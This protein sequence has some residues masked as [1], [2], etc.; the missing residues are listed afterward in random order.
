MFKNSTRL[1]FVM[2]ALGPAIVFAQVGNT[3]VNTA[4]PG[5]TIDI[6]GSVA[7]NYNAV[8]TASYNLNSSDFHVSYNGTSDAVFSLPSAINGVGNFKGRIY[9]IKN[10]TSFT[11]TVNPAAPETINGNT[12]IAIPANQGLQLI[13]TGLTGANS[14]WEILSTGASSVTASNGLTLSGTDVKLGGTLSQPTDI[15]TAGNNLSINGTGKVL[16]GTNTLPTGGA[17][18][19]VVIDNGATNGALQIKDGTEKLGY[20][21]TSDANGLATWSSTVTTAFAN[22]W[23]PYTGTLVNPFTGTVGGGNLSTGISV[24]IPAK[25]W[26]FFRCGIT[27]QANCNDFAFYINGI[28]DIWRTYCNVADV[29]MMSPRDQN[30]VLYFSTPGTYLV[31]ALKTNGTVPSGFNIGNPSF[32]LDFVKFQN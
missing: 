21:L 11:I 16:V 24:T 9:R 4:N 17:N 31:S 20:V 28:G 30:R 19:K 5:S 3:G 27:I 15:I 14:T 6:N 25:G 7:A 18:A 12:S 22:S 10:N 26:Y 32:Y 1:I 8:S 29:Q 13:N 2:M 23:T